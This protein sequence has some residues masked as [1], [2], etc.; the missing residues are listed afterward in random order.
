MIESKPGDFIK[1]ILYK[2][3]IKILNSRLFFIDHSNETYFC[4]VY[5]LSIFRS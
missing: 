5:N 4:P 3:K 1:I 2:K